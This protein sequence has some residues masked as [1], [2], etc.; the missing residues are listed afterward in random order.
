MLESNKN[1]NE[2]LVVVKSQGFV[3]TSLSLPFQPVRKVCCE[4]WTFFR[5]GSS[6]V[7]ALSSAYDGDILRKACNWIDAH[8]DHFG[9]TILDI[10]T[11]KLIQFYYSTAAYLQAG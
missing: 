11:P 2:N 5:R 1:E 8:N 10:K 7:I 3:V 4:G 6:A 9:K